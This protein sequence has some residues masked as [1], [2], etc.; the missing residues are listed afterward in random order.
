MAFDFKQNSNRLKELIE[1]KPS[2][3][4]N[5]YVIEMIATKYDAIAILAA[6]VLAHWG[7]T[8]D[9]EQIKSWYNKRVKNRMKDYRPELIPVFE[10]FLKDKNNV[11]WLIQ[12]YI[13]NKELR[14][15][16]SFA[17]RKSPKIVSIVQRFIETDEPILIRDVIRNYMFSNSSYN[18]ILTNLCNHFSG[19]VQKAA[20]EQS[21]LL[22]NHSE[23]YP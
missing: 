3:E 2:K 18:Q 14:T 17:L 13:E 22:K 10:A 21:S 7:R 11:D 9:I 19:E 15:T 23:S 4:N 1:T 6:K 5:I 12:E 16:I 20:R 8:E